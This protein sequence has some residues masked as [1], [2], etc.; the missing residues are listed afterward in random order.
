MKMPQN[1]LNKIYLL[2]AEKHVLQGD[3]D[4]AL[5][6][7]RASA[8]FAKE[9]GVIQEQA[10]AYERAAIALDEWGEVTEATDSIKKAMKLYKQW[11]CLW[12]VAQLGK[13]PLMTRSNIATLPGNSCH[14]ERNQPTAQTQ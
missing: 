10:L 13:L 11:G 7:F 9:L 8:N 2:E 3:K 4:N 6:K 12:K 14:I 5:L 1:V